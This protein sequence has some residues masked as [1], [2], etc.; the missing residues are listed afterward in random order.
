[1]RTTRRLAEYAAIPLLI[2]FGWWLVTDR[3]WVRPLFLPHPAD[4]VGAF[5][6]AVADGSLLRHAWASSLRVALGFLA[7][8]CLAFPLG[9]L[10][11]LSPTGRR[12]FQPLNSLM[13]YTPFPAFI[14]LLILWFGISTVS[15]L[16]VVFV[17]TFFQ[18]AVLIQDA[19]ADIHREYIETARSLSFPAHRTF[20]RVRLPAALPKCYDAIR[21]GI[22]WAWTCL[23]VAE[24]VGA[25]DGL[26][27]MIIVA[28][29]FLNT[30]NVYIGILTIGAIGL[31]IDGLLRL[32]RPYVAPW[33]AE[34]RSA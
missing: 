18:L 10:M 22:G 5:A 30:P 33:A 12:L 13:R 29:R 2:V 16:S 28:Q 21:I 25:S 32:A 17:G 3:G 4:L 19:F 14:P 26:G 9:V 11:A 34:V 24:M 23:I 20:L 15:Q 1:M 6:D 7:S 8:L 31:S 27:Y